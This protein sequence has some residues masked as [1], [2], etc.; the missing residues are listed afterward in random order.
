MNASIYILGE[1]E[2]T[3]DDLSRFPSGKLVQIRDH[4]ISQASDRM[5]A[6]T[7]WKAPESALLG[8]TGGYPFP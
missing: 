8:I 6:R 1:A 4:P 3:Y 2:F 5:L 7:S